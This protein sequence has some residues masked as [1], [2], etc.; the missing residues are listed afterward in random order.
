MAP[1]L[2]LLISTGD[3]AGQP[4]YSQLQPIARPLM[5]ERRTRVAWTAA[6]TVAGT[7]GLDA[8]VATC[9]FIE[10][11]RKRFYWGHLFL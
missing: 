8:A 10:R 1:F 9:S 6:E 2:V 4:V 3:V 5:D 11:G 7:V